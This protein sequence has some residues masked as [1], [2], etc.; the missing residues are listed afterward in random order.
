ML[1]RMNEFTRTRVV[2]AVSAV[3]WLAH[4]VVVTGWG[5]SSRGPLLSDVIQFALGATLIYA[6]VL[7]SRRSEGL[8][9]SFWR[10]ATAAYVAWLVAQGLGLYNGQAAS[11]VVAWI[12]NLL[13]CFWFAPL[14]MAL[15][16]D[17]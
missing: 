15:F 17:P 8:A 12:S 14:A 4:L 11:A 10:L 13:F 5:T 6:T 7:A 2:L 16:L 9:R 3:L 1:H